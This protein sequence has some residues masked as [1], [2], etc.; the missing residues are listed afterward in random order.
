ME[1]RDQR[2]GRA[3]SYPRGVGPE[4]RR[5]AMNR[6]LRLLEQALAP[7]PRRQAPLLAVNCGNGAMLPFFW[8]CGFDVQATE[9][10][11]SLRLKALQLQLPGTEVYAARDDDLPFENDSFDW[12]VIHLKSGDQK[13]IESCH[14]EG[15]RLARRGLMVTFWNSQ[16]LA[17]LCWRIAHGR[18]WA[19]SAASWWVVWRHLRS[20][21]LGRVSTLSTLALPPF[22]WKLLSQKRAGTIPLGAWCAVRVDM[23]P[24]V[25]FTPLPLRLGVNF[26]APET[27]L[28]PVQTRTGPSPT[29]NTIKNRRNPK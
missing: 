10:D 12:V 4:E 21:E 23:A 19:E 27:G 1:A 15:A 2:Q 6:Q 18:T 22:L 24:A 5:L 16:S 7:W 20:L 9:E 14:K 26:R 17:A 11:A 28:E 13:G 3:A 25:P 29:A 8:H